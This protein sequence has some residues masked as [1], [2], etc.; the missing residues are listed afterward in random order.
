V[1]RLFG[2]ANSC[3]KPIVAMEIG[4]S[5]T[6]SYVQVLVNFALLMKRDSG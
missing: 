6:I 4:M 5:V 3:R 1:R 2:S